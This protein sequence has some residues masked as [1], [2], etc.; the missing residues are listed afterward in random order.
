[1]YKKFIDEQ[2][3]FATNEDLKIEIVE[4]KSSLETAKVAIVDNFYKNPELVRDLTL[5]I[6]PTSNERITSYL[7]SGRNSGR[8]NAFYLM[9]S[10]GPVY[11]KLIRKA[12]S[13]IV[14]PEFARSGRVDQILESFKRAT[15]MANV[16]TSENLPPRVPHIDCPDYR[17]FASTIFLNTEDECAGGTAF[18]SFGEKIYSNQNY[19]TIDIQ[20]TTQPSKFV[21]EDEGDWKKLYVAEMKYNRMVFYQQ[22]IFHNAYID[23][24]MFLGDTYRLNQQF[25]I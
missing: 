16:M 11:D 14:L 24:T 9:D 5:A 3:V 7:P 20:G 12:F 1:M 22:N 15:F 18:Y 17:A 19:N 8:I 4:I 2:E 25:F 21:I 6:P 23:E 13:E 10:L